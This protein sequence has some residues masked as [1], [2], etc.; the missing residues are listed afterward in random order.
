[1]YRPLKTVISIFPSVH[2]AMMQTAQKAFT[3]SGLCERLCDRKWLYS[4][5][6]Q[7]NT[8]WQ[9]NSLSLYV[10]C[11]DNVSGRS[12]RFQKTPVP[13]TPLASKSPF[14]AQANPIAS[15]PIRRREKFPQMQHCGSVRTK[16]VTYFKGA[17]SLLGCLLLLLYHFSSFFHGPNPA[18]WN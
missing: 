12:F 17:C 16:F 18:R 13:L 2:W 7:S 4:P 6:F 14:L 8:L 5:D 11:K 10:Q 15:P 1:M 3:K 9:S